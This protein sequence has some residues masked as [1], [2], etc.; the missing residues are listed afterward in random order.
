[1]E[2]VT[3]EQS[4]CDDNGDGDGADSNVDG[5]SDDGGNGDGDGDG[6]DEDEYV[7]QVATDRTSPE[8]NGNDIEK[9]NN[10]RLNFD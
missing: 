2:T 4:H 9:L 8:D 6:V 7:V 3:S 10:K 5:G 1:M